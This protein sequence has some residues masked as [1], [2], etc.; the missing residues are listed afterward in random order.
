MMLT[1]RDLLLSVGQKVTA[2][3]CGIKYTISVLGWKDKEFILTDAPKTSGN[4]LRLASLTGI[5]I[6]YAKEGH[7]I[8][9]D[10][11]VVMCHSQP[12]AYMLIEFPQYLGKDNMRKHERYKAKIPIH[13]NKIG[14]S[15]VSATIYDLSLG[16][17]LIAHTEPLATG[18]TIQIG[19]EWKELGATLS[20]LE[21]TV[22]N[23]RESVQ[24][25]KGLIFS[26]VMFW[27]KADKVPQDLQ[28]IIDYLVKESR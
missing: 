4:Y 8:N 1:S 28:K 6:R 24:T 23:V 5:R 11:R 10:T 26:G 18:E 12:P 17:A 13:Y 21:A 3:V 20:G 7:A 2:I 19:L 14:K 15:T 9:F 16:G 25:K 22:Q 27:T